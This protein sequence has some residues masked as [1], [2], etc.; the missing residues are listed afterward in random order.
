M[1]N[2]KHLAMTTLNLS[3]LLDRSKNWN[4]IYNQ[5]LKYTALDKNKI[6][7]NLFEEFCKQYY[8]VEPS[9]KNEYKNVWLFSEIPQKIKDKL[10]LGKVDHG[11]DL[12]LEGQ[13][14]TLS[15]VQC[16]FRNHQGG[17]ISWSKDSLANL[18]AD[19][20]KAD[21]FIVFTNASGLDKHSLTK[22]I[23]QLKLVTLGDLLNISSSTINEI[24]K[25]ISNLTSAPTTIKTPREYQ[26]KAIQDVINGFQNHD[27][28]Q[29]I[30]PCG[31]GKTLVSLWIKEKLKSKHTLVLVPS[32]ALLRQIK[33]EWAANSNRF[34]P[35]ICVC[36]EKDINKE[37]DRAVVH[38]YEIGGKVSTI[39]NEIL[40]FLNN[41][42]ETIIYSTYQSLG[43]ICK[44]IK[45]SSFSFDLAICDEA[46]KTSGSKLSNFGLVHFDTNILVKKR[47]YMTATPRV[48]SDGLKNELND[49]VIKYIHDM[50]NPSIFGHE[51]HRMSFKQ[52]ID[53]KI[54][55]D[56][57]IMAIGINDKEIEEAIKQRKY[58]S[59][60]ETIDEIA[61][62]YALEKFMQKHSPTHAITF[63]S[64]VKKAKSFQA[65]HNE[66]YPSVAT[67]HVNGELTT[68]ERN[69]F[70]KEFERS[71][72][73]V[74]TNAR[75]LTEGVDV[76]AIDVVYFCDPKNS[77]IDI[78]QA[79][80]RALRRADH[81]GK[82]IGYVV[83]PVFHRNKEIIEEIIDTSAFKNL[84][85]VIRALCA[86]DERLVEE[87]KEIKLGK[88]KRNIRTQHFSI[89][90]S[91]NLIILEGFH[92]KL[93]N[94]L[95]DQLINKV[96]IPAKNFEEAR[97]FARSL[98]LSGKKAWEIYCL[99]G[100][101]PADIPSKPA[102]TY[103]KCG[104]LGW[105]DFLG[106]GN[107]HPRENNFLPFE[108]ARKYVHT[109]GLKNQ[110]AWQA[111][112]R[113]DKRPDFIPVNPAQAYE[114]K[115][116]ISWPDWLGSNTKHPGYKECV[117]YKKA[118][119]YA[120]RLKLKSAREWTLHWRKH[121]PHN[122]PA[123]P[124]I[125]YKHEG[126]IDWGT[127]L[128]TGTIQSQ[129]IN[130]KP[131]EKARS[132]VHKLKLKNGSEWKMYCGSGD[133]PKDIPNNPR[134]TYK[135]S[136]WISMPDWL[137]TDNVH[138][139]YREYLPYNEAKTIVRSFNIKSVSA[140]RTFCKS[141]KLPKNIPTAP[142]EHYKISGWIDWNDWLGNRN[143]SP[144]DY[145][146][147]PFISAKKIV[148]ELNFK[149]IHEWYAFCN[150]G[151]RP[152]NIP[153]NPSSY[154]KNDGWT[155]WPDWFGTAKK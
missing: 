24:K 140:W 55:V 67:Y 83:V 58:I 148:R 75:C 124:D 36:S 21:Y 1:L 144:H 34:I 133:K 33:N 60:N 110:K 111:Y 85:S 12:V 27:R 121:K 69:V 104:W 115:G 92:G 136:G 142:N 122:I 94:N 47:L 125:F 16:K 132:F 5:L 131:F 90:L 18:F 50:S 80:G 19:G 109:L 143:K 150:S 128:G 30:L 118:E 11:I 88:G 98:K 59:D 14:N 134:G 152:D 141:N 153:S 123:K 3:A 149:N 4:D 32:L 79:T 108:K 114:K 91:C 53:K 103:K 78:V 76:P 93:E 64:S 9:V 77:K 52:A 120:R 100:K 86:H 39:P 154:Y 96:R 26:Q 56:Y 81:K 89:N 127:F 113:S 28:G 22:K 84:V 116:W 54:L 147:L 8:L 65:R 106:T 45:N 117:P 35:Y 95:F 146:F 41:H 145:N 129:K 63:H 119:Q 57:Q 139:Q 151:K 42:H 51:L 46:H 135:N 72:K 48:L 82:K 40:D 138:T 126:W 29:L 31:A 2:I 17:N 6:I 155:S 101:R 23:N 73:S 44:A 70:I 87:I 25:Y 43:T 7:G 20:D 38:T 62:N 112:A 61:N 66:I 71:P 102:R 107:M 10:Q 137:G 37:K 97:A 74:M 105:G 99:S 49:D 15:V 68:N 130:W 13:D